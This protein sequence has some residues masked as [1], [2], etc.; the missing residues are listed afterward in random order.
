MGAFNFTVD[1]R[2]EE[3]GWNANWKVVIESATSESKTRATPEAAANDNRIVECL[4]FEFRAIENATTNFS[5]DSKLGEGGFGK[6]CKGTFLDGKEIAVKR[7]S[8]SSRQGI[9]EFKNEAMVVAKL[10]HIN[11]HF[12]NH[13]GLYAGKSKSKI[14]TLRIVAIVPPVTVSVVLFIVM[15]FCFLIRK[16]INKFYK[17]DDENVANEI[18]NVE[19]SQFEF[20]A[21]EIATNNFSNDNKLGEGGFGKV[22]EGTL[23]DE[24]EIAVKRLSISSRQG[25]VEF[26]N[27][28]MVVAKLQ[29]RNL[30]RLLGFCM[31]KEEKILVYEYV[32]NGSLDNFL[33]GCSGYMSLEYAMHVFSVKSDVFSFGV[34]LH[35]I[36][37]RQ[38]SDGTRLNYWIQLF[39]PLYLQKMKS[40]DASI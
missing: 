33:H 35:K 7:L 6:V 20:R 2:N 15:V 30:V 11:P 32:P 21:I 14:L 18:R 16:A 28:V 25:A 5:N 40:L 13:D 24:K 26:R 38:W 8:I 9:V 29:H 31:T 23:P 12:L 17:L 27:E 3:L 1:G 19:C 39:D 10:Q 4:Q 37:L 36:A 34:M 22:Y